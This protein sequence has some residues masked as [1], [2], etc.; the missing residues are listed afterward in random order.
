L[1]LLVGRAKLEPIAIKAAVSKTDLSE[2]FKSDP[3]EMLGGTIAI[4]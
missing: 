1:P 3:G 4:E 2:E